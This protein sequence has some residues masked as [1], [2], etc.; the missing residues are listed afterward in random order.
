[1]SRTRLAYCGVRGAYG[2]EENNLL[3]NVCLFVGGPLNCGRT[4][5]VVTFND[6]DRSNSNSGEKAAQDPRRTSRR[7]PR[8]QQHERLHHYSPQGI[9]C[10]FCCEK[11][12]MAVVLLL[13]IT[14][15]KRR[16]MRVKTRMVVYCTAGAAERMESTQHGGNLPDVPV[17]EIDSYSIP[18]SFG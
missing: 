13:S 16:S 3:R 8:R 9:G 11:E 1:M 12:S 2:Q 5:C 18:T 10:L 7:L 15:N 14:S 4:E 17:A 6:E